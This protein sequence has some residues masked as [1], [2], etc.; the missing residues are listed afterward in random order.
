MKFEI[1]ELKQ[2]DIPLLEDFLYNAIYVP[3]RESAPPRT[4]LQKP[5]LRVYVDNFGE[6]EADYAYVATIGSRAVGAVWARIMPD[7]GHIDDHTPSLAISVHEE[8]RGQGIGTALMCTI[9]QK[10]A[11]KGYAAVSLSVQKA[12]PALRLYTRLGF[13]PISELSDDPAEAIMRKRLQ[14]MG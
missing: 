11:E 13:E 5:E 2:K 3:E 12:N 1:S 14:P 4:I 8:W 9:L 10:L 6:N 7:Y